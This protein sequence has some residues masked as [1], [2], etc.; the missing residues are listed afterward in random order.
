MTALTAR[1]EAAWQRTAD[2]VDHMDKDTA[3]AKRAREAADAARAEVRCCT[4]ASIPY[5]LNPEYQ[6]RNRNP[7]VPFHTLN[8]RKATAAARAEVRSCTLA[9]IPLRSRTVRFRDQ[10]CRCTFSRSREQRCAPIRFQALGFRVLSSGFR[11][12]LSAS[13]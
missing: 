13:V 5:T 7:Y 4:L 12:S 1:H 9:P 8:P 3:E 10:C 6:A 2:A 11:V